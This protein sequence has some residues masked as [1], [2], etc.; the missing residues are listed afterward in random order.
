MEEEKQR[1]VEI[2]KEQERKE[3]CE[4]EEVFESVG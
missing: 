2:R 3:E 1:N 4:N